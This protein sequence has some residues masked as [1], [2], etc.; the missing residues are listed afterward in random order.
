MLHLQAGVDFQ[1]E[2]LLP[3]GVGDELHG[4]RA[5][6]V[7]L[8]NQHPRGLLHSGP[9]FGRH[10]R[11][12]GLFQH[13]L[14]A[15]LQAA[16]ALEEAGDL[17]VGVGKHLDFDVAGPLDE[18]LHHHVVV[19]KAAHGLL[20][21]AEDLV[22]EVLLLPHDPHAPP[23][24]TGAG[25]EHHGQAHLLCGSDQLVIR[26]S[27]SK[28][29]GNDGGAGALGQ[30]FG[31]DFGPESPHGAG[32]GANEGEARRD[33]G[34]SEFGSLRKKAVARVN[35]VGAREAGGL[36]D[37]GDGEVAFGGGGGADLDGVIREPGVQGASVSFAEDRHR[38]NAHAAQSA[39]NAAG[40]LSAIGDEDAAYSHGAASLA[41][42]AATPALPSSPD[43]AL[44]SSRAPSSRP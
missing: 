29:S 1:E 36:Q 41:R 37:A 18:A 15:P 22:G 25:L 23:A 27:G 24:A 38:A 33:D 4:S 26:G 11:R 30:L 21:G 39:E 9:N 13:L 40:D 3:G 5:H 31:G 8:Q 7:R 44:A 16:F 34:F 43:R 10:H 12:G 17:A 20:A 42:K 28:P 6:I 14:A 19:A 2:E 35:G 32:R